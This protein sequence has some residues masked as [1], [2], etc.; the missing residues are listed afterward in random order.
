MARMG[1]LAAPIA[2]RCSRTRKL[3]ARGSLAL[4]RPRLMSNEFMG[5]HDDLPG[6]C[7]QIRSAACASMRSLPAC[8]RH[9]SHILSIGSPTFRSFLTTHVE[10][11][12]PRRRSGVPSAKCLALQGK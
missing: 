6:N 5:A 11:E 1:R 10:D 9:A 2:G 12:S 4:A 8:S 3:S 7:S